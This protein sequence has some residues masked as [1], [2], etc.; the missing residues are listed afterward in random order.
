MKNAT[1]VKEM[2]CYRIERF[3]EKQKQVAV[4]DLTGELKRSREKR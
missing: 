1:Y 4:I 3:T 2:F